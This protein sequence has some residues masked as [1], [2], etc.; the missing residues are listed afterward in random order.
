M[1]P[2]PT[3]PGDYHIVPTRPSPLRI[4]WRD[5]P[6]SAYPGLGCFLG[7]AAFLA[8]VSGCAG[9]QDFHPR[10]VPPIAQQGSAA[11]APTG[12]AP[13]GPDTQT[14]AIVDGVRVGAERVHTYAD[15]AAGSVAFEEAALDA[16]LDR[17]LAASSISITPD[18]AQTELQ[19]LVAALTT[20]G[21]VSK[22]QTGVVLERLKRQRGLGPARFQAL[23][24][25]NAK[26]RALVAPTVD[27][28]PDDL[29]TALAVEFGPK[30]RARVLTVATRELAADLR[31]RISADTVDPLTAFARLA[32]Q[33]STDP[34]AGV[35][36]VIEPMSPADV[37]L[38]P[39]LR[40]AITDPP[41]GLLP[42]AVDT[43]RGFTLVYVE[44]K[45]PARAGA[46]PE[47]TE[48]VRTKARRRLERIAM[49]RLGRQLLDRAKIT[50]LDDAVRWSWE[51]RPR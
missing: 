38:A 28:T 8:G 47:E 36:G 30:V 41:L 1:T 50:I 23:L 6:A 9:P 3:E 44:E 34:S 46:T 14:L 15:E 40:Q 7:F 10:T 48:R 21:N 19:Y 17:E 33:F 39:A 27:V 25:R 24:E 16:L 12:Q 42:E 49:D 20:D 35:G 4:S 11:A 32:S 43:G 29:K 5:F 13:P 37:S 26:L 51:S 2:R 22:E 31:A 45:T 18:A